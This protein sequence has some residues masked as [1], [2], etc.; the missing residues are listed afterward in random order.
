M[1]WQ[2][3]RRNTV[4]SEN[5]KSEMGKLLKKIGKMVFGK[6]EK[7]ISLANSDRKLWQNVSYVKSILRKILCSKISW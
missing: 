7:I 5:S 4:L 6:S 1:D 2:I 3:V